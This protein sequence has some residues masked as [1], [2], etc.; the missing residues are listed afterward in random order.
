MQISFDI[1]RELYEYR[2]RQSRI[3]SSTRVR[4]EVDMFSS[5]RTKCVHADDE[6]GN[7]VRSVGTYVLGKSSNR[8]VLKLEGPY[9]SPS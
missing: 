7:E 1:G 3:S 2:R 6:V 5:R 4:A 9:Q 8:R